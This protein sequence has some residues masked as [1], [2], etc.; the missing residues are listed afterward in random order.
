MKLSYSSSVVEVYFLK[1]GKPSA[2]LRSWSGLCSAEGLHDLRLSLSHFRSQFASLH[3]TRPTGRRPLP[4]QSSVTVH[5][6]CKIRLWAMAGGVNKLTMRTM[7]GSGSAAGSADPAAR[8]S[9]SCRSSRRRM[10]IT[11]CWPAVK[12]WSAASW[13]I[14]PGKTQRRR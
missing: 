3:P 8:H 5:F 11:A 14:V 9:P 7:T 2:A 13:T 4:K 6:V 12:R 10:R 1:E